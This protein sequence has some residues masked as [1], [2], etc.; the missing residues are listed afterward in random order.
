LDLC[1]CPLLDHL[2]RAAE[3]LPAVSRTLVLGNAHRA[4]LEAWLHESSHGDWKTVIQEQALGTGDAVRAGLAA[5]PAQGWVLILCGDTPLL[6]TETLQRMAAEKKNLLLTATLD[7][8]F[9]YGRIVRNEEGELLGIVEEADADEETAAVAEV[10]AGVYVLDLA[11]LRA[12]VAGLRADNA[13]GEFYLTNAVLEVLAEQG[14]VTLCLEDGGEEILGVNTLPDLAEASFH[15]RRR[16]LQGHM[17]AGVVVSDPASTYIEDGVEIGPGT[18]ILPFSVIRRG[19]RIGSSCMVGPFAHL[20]PGTVLADGAELGN[21]VEAKNAELGRGAKAKH[22]TY[23][24]DVAVGAFANIG[25]GTITANYDGRKKHRTEIG[26]RA[27]IGSGTILVAPVRVGRK[28]VTGAGAVVPHDH[29]VP[30]GTTVLGV[31]AR[32]FPHPAPSCPD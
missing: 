13:Q 28:A 21:F 20:R 4:P 30:E 25:C 22:L 5:L 32:P 2:L 6:Q 31:P 29:D 3:G 24:G 15:L 18:R 8:P 26:E 23:L 12:A 11:G 19:V 27:F 9:G 1:G 16:I 14:G 10:N 7:D 17:A